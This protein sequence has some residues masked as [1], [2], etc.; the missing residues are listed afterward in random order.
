MIY[1]RHAISDPSTSGIS[2]QAGLLAEYTPSQSRLSSNFHDSERIDPFFR[3]FSLSPAK[4][5]PPS[6]ILKLEIS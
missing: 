2:I 1:G 5:D 3:S 4:L 6:Y